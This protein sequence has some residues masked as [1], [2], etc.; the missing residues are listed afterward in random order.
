MAPATGSAHFFR[1]PTQFGAW[2][3]SSQ[4]AAGA[5]HG[6]AVHE[7]DQNTSMVQPLE[8]SLE[9]DPDNYGASNHTSPY[10]T[11]SHTYP[12]ST[13]AVSA[14][15]NGHAAGGKS[16]WWSNVKDKVS[17]VKD[18]VA[19][20][21][22]AALTFGSRDLRSTVQ[23]QASPFEASPHTPPPA[24]VEGQPDVPGISLHEQGVMMSWVLNCMCML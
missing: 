1:P 4:H 8:T 10:Y 21:W 12:H 16:S 3:Q 15:G 18:K 7:D 19:S 14:Y 11:G 6:Y 2:S 13:A 23:H 5:A 9:T 20:A 24:V 22:P 17:S